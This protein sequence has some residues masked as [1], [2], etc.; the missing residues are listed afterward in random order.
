MWDGEIRDYLRRRGVETVAPPSLQEYHD[1]CRAL[2]VK[3]TLRNSTMLAYLDNLGA[4]QQPDIFKRFYWWEEAY[5][6]DMENAFGVT[7]D[8]RSYKDLWARALSIP[9]FR[10]EDEVARIAG[11]VPIVGLATRARHDAV[12]L[13]LALSD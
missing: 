9:N 3:K 1:I 7:V 4:G 5:V 13:K 10:V 2:A 8:R 6:T 12:R 11:P